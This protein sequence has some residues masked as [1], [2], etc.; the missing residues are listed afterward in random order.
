M[1]V[2]ANAADD[3]IDVWVIGNFCW[4]SATVETSSGATIP[5]GV[6]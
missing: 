1:S 3:E 5:S 4:I 6:S 2:D